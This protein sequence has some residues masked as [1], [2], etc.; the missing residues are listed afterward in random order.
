MES[1]SSQVGKMERRAE[2]FDEAV[3]RIMELK[4]SIEYFESGELAQEGLINAFKD[5]ISFYESSSRAFVD[6]LASDGYQEGVLKKY[7]DSTFNGEKIITLKATSEGEVFVN[8][9]SGEHFLGYMDSGY[10]YT[11]SFDYILCG[12]SFIDGLDLLE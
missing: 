6:K 12:M 1:L 3:D 2:R 11:D 5:L 10:S 7:S 9:Q 4:R 8:T